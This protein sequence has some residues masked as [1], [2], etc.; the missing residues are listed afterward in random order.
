MPDLSPLYAHSGGVL[1]V[2]QSG[3]LLEAA[4]QN[5]GFFAAGVGHGKTLASLLLYWAMRSV[6]QVLLV[7]AQL[8]SKTLLTDLPTY[9]ARFRLPPVYDGTSPPPG[10]PPGVYVVAY[11]DLSQTDSSDLL[12][13]LSP[14]LIVAD[15]AHKLRRR[16]ASRTKRFLRYMRAHRGVC[17]FVAMTGSPMARE[18]HDFAHLLDLALGLGSPLPRDYPTLAQ[19]SDHL[20][21]DKIGAGALTLLCAPGESVEDAFR[22]RLH[23]TPGVICTT[24]R[25]IDLPLHIRLL[26]PSPP[27]QVRAALAELANTWAWGGVEYDSVL[28]VVQ[29]SRQ[30]VQGY[31]YRLVWPD[32]TPDQ[33]WLDARNAWSRAIRSRLEHTSIVDEDSPALL[34]RLAESGEWCPPAWPQWCAVRDRP[35]PP[36][37]SVELSRWLVDLVRGW[38]GPG[39][40]WVD[41]P[42]VGAWLADA[43]IPY[44]GE[45]QD[46]AVNALASGPQA[47]LG[48]IAL[49]WR[50]HGT[51]K[52][53]QAWCRNL[54]LYP[55][56]GNDAWE[57]LLGRT[58]RPG[59]NAP[60][61]H[62]DVVL[63]CPAAETAWGHALEYAKR[64]EAKLGPQALN[65]ASI[66]D[67]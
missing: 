21:A 23:E 54:V 26:R 39:L 42:I 4:Q 62:V 7:P 63:A 48:T 58:L 24:D 60:S 13:Q 64:V 44:Y 17:R 14:D 27:P 1:R 5:G 18:L 53:L 46:D 12:D 8:K 35:A 29:M 9:R 36:R 56:A 20:D 47:G 51:G 50:A 22:R 52:N 15:E 43:G 28:S 61:V 33:E 16:D 10:L 3:I 31:Y 11:E 49:S 57:Q 25:S 37:E 6:R 55:P 2:L 59:Q 32:G 45:G 66:E 19:W 34:E 67:A 65:L 30:L 41:S 40:V 38:E